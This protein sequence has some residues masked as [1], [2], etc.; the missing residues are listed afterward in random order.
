ML[1][2]G[3]LGVHVLNVAIYCSFLTMF[4]IVK[5]P[6]KS[7]E[8]FAV[9]LIFTVVALIS[10]SFGDFKPLEY[11]GLW[12]FALNCGLLIAVVAPEQLSRFSRTF[13][14]TSSLCAVIYLVLLLGGAIPNSYGRYS[15]FAGSHPNLG[16][17]IFAIASFVGAL[18]MTKRSFL[19]GILPMLVATYFM[20]TRTGTVVIFGTA[21]VKLVLERD[22]RITKG[23]V[24]VGGVVLM[25]LGLALM[26]EGTVPKLVA[27]RV[28]LSDDVRRGADTGFVS[29]RNGQWAAAISYF[30]ESPIIG[31]GLGLYGGDV[32][33]AHNPFLY[34]ISIYGVF[35]LL[36][37]F[38]I[39]PS[40]VRLSR[41]DPRAFILIL[42]TCLMMILNDRFLNSNAFPLLFYFYIIQLVQSGTRIVPDQRMFG[43]AN[44]RK[45]RLVFKG[46]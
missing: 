36:F 8:L 9:A 10:D 29:G 23:T 24:F 45:L 42:P 1:P 13:F 28:L 25:L 31:N 12:L 18:A 27:E 46:A 32:R 14:L 38:W 16:G 5:L 2:G 22:E 41:H 6:R 39:L 21:V 17:E 11:A 33:G 30:R 7:V 43:N 35:G 19:I 40:F 44:R 15:F 37:W 26:L 34:S 3:S 4:G 20:Q